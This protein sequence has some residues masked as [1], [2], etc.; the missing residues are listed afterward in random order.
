MSKEYNGYIETNKGE[1]MKALPYHQ[2]HIVYTIKDLSKQ[3]FE[4]TPAGANIS[5]KPHAMQALIKKGIVREVERCKRR[6][7]GG[8]WNYTAYELVEGA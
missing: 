2:E 3:G 5:F 4:L 8:E 1:H 7:D 6:A